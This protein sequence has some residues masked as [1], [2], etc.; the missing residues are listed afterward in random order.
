LE[1]GSHELGLTLGGP[2]VVVGGAPIPLP[3][4]N[5]EG[6][7]GVAAPLERELDV[8]YG[9]NL[10]GLAFGILQMHAGASWL[11]LDQ[12]GAVPAIALTDRIFFATNAL[13]LK[14]KPE[15]EAL[16]WAANQIELNL[17]WLLGGQLLYAGLAEYL[18]FG[19]PSLTLTPVLGAVFDPA[20]ARETGVRLH[21]E[22]RWFAVN[23][24]HVLDT[25]TWVPNNRGGIGVALGVS[26]L[27]EVQR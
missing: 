24:P 1:P 14:W 10:T 3:N 16:G 26:Y 12:R 4:A 15:G 22:G 5:L 8:N 19:N 11:L 7:S 6:R 21:L 20:P 23:Q 18:D 17:S 13:G 9:I 25:V 27:F 2:F